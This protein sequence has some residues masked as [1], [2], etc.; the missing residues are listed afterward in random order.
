MSTGKTRSAEFMRIKKL[1]NNS[2]YYK[3]IK[4][5]LV[6]F[7]EN[8]CTMKMNV[9]DL[10]C[11]VYEK[12]HGGSLA[13]LAD[14]ACSLALVTAIKDNEFIATQNLSINYLL[15]VTKGVLTAEGYVIHRD[16]YSAVLGADIFNE[17][18]EIVAHAHSI[19]V[20]RESFH[21]QSTKTPPS[22]H[23]INDPISK[24]S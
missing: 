2:P 11:N 14:S 19:H 22:F 12:A 5:E 17:G 20:I 18:G 24:S 23:R 16:R 3:H 13:S 10:H 6:D 8:G 1:V 7:K 9:E 21:S 15:P 4:M